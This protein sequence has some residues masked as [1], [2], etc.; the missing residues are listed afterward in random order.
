MPPSRDDILRE[1]KSSKSEAILRCAVRSHQ[2]NQFKKTSFSSCA[3]NESTVA[4]LAV[5]VKSRLN[6]VC[7]FFNEP[8]ARKKGT[9]KK[10]NKDRNNIQARRNKVSI[11]PMKKCGKNEQG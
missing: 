2:T 1:Q 5:P 3:K 4:K 10:K 8:G 7:Q 6:H 9:G 11:A